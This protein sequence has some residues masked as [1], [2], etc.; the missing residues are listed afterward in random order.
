MATRQAARREGF[1][2]E[3]RAAMKDHA[4]D[5][6]AAARGGSKAEK[7]AQA[8][9]DVLDKIAE[10]DPAD[11]ERA[12]RVH[13][14][15]LAAAPQLEPKLWY[16]MPAYALDGKLLCHFQPSAKFKTRY[17][18]LGFSDLAKLDDGALWP[19]AYAVTEVT[20]EVEKQITALVR[21]AIG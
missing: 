15:V 4:K 3:E 7:A 19:V 18:T 21:R 16:G 1:S 17:P 14:V 12:E 13:A 6:K 9:Q 2:A 10:L 5:L 20:A 8:R 11:R